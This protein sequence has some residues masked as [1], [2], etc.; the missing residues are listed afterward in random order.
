VDWET[1][2]AI[3]QLSEWHL[4]GKIAAPNMARSTTQL[5]PKPGDEAEQELPGLSGAKCPK[6]GEIMV[7]ATGIEPVTPT[8]SR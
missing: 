3:V 5:M 7:G 6:S 8:V 4:T 2:A 1:R